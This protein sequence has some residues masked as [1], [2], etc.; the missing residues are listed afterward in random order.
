M[1]GYF[2]VSKSDPFLLFYQFGLVW[3]LIHFD[4]PYH[5]FFSC[6]STVLH[7]VSKLNFGLTCFISCFLFSLQLTRYNGVYSPHQPFKTLWIMQLILHI[8]S[9]F[10]LRLILISILC[11]CLPP[12]PFSTVTKPAKKTRNP[13]VY[14]VDV[15]V[16]LIT[17]WHVV[18]SSI[19][20]LM[21]ISPHLVS[22]NFHPQNDVTLWEIIKTTNTFVT[23]DNKEL[24]SYD[25]S[26]I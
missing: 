22:Y 24:G 26:P 20:P 16:N 10:S 15:Q 5:N 18:I 7:E 4:R 8:F 2:E 23:R 17:L 12:H 9:L 3:A 19:T 25:L 11:S 6:K 13:S 21:K 14:H 1:S